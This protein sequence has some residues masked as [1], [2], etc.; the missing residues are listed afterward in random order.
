MADDAA[1]TF[2][3]A[4]FFYLGLFVLSAVASWIL[5]DHGDA[6]VHR[7]PEMES[8]RLPDGGPLNGDCVG[9]GAVLRISFATFAFHLA[10]AAT[11]AGCQSEDDPRTA[12]HTSCLGAKLASWVALATVAF[13]IP[14][15]FFGV[16]GELARVFSGVF[17][18]FQAIVM[19]DLVYR[20]NEALIDRPGCVPALVAAAFALYALAMTVIALCYHFYAPRGSCSTNV[21]WIT[22]TLIMALG[23]SA[24]SVSPWRIDRAGLMTSGAVFAYTAYLLLN[25]LTSQPRDGSNPCVAMGGMDG[26]WIQVVGFL[27]ALGAV[28]MSTLSTGTS[29]MLPAGSTSG[30]PLPYRPDFF[31][32]TFSLAAMYLAMLF[33]SWSLEETPDEWVLDKGWQSA[34]V[35]IASQWLVVAL[36]VWTMIAPRLLPD[37]DF[38]WA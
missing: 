15:A 19:L 17:L 10:H 18:I 32:A 4:K 20:I 8:C 38:S 3:T 29:D 11:L 27:I 16:Y 28:I 22:W 26:D 33:T 21:G 9:K 1:A 14:N 23:Y 5:R 35:K 6:F 24:L 7:L 12:A 36:Y 30:P 2:A 13:F 25:A 34:W 37:R 31:H